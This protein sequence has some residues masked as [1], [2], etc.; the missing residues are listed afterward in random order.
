LTWRFVQKDEEKIMWNIFRSCFG[1]V[2]L[3]HI[4]VCFASACCSLKPVELVCCVFVVVVYF[5]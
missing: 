5:S 2:N 3:K 1:G 4:L